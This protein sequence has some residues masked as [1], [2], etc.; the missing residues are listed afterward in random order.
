MKGVR[1]HKLNTGYINDDSLPN[2]DNEALSIIEDLF[3]LDKPPEAQIDYF[4]DD[5]VWAD[6]DDDIDDFF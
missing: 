5:L 4:A 3:K 1:K 6:D 2:I